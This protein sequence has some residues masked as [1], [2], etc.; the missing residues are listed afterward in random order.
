MATS[1]GSPWNLPSPLAPEQPDGPANFGDLADAVH[2][3]LGRAYPCVSG[4]RPAAVEGMLIFE[5]DT[6]TL[7]VSLDGSTWTAVWTPT[8]WI[9]PAS[10]FSNSWVNYGGS[11]RVF[12][13]WKD[14]FGWVHLRGLVK[15]G[16]VA[17]IYTL[18]V[19]YRPSAGE[20]FL[21]QSGASG[22]VARIDV[23]STGAINL[24]GYGASG[25]NVSVS[26]SGISFYAG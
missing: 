10:P 14:V 24:V 2:A 20:T 12:G 11:W 23:L 17:T 25:S 6:D 4:A 21:S 22:Y 1:T 7:L 3:A 18:P 8:V 5:T 13:Y 26:L 9:E 15:S 16:S 19:G